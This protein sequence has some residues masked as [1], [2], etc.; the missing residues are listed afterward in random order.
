MLRPS[1]ARLIGFVAGAAL[2]GAPLQAQLRITGAISGT[3]QDPSGGAVAGAELALR[4]EGTGIV[5]KGAASAAGNFTFPDLAHGSYELTVTAPGFQQAVVSRITVSTSQTTDVPVRLAV[6]QQSETV[7]VEG[8]APALERTS[9]LVTSTLTPKQITEL[10]VANRSNVLALAR[11]APGATP[12]TQGSTRYNN[13]PGGAVNV[14]VDGINDA[15]NGFKSGGTVFFMTVPVRVGAVEEVSVET[16]GLGAE[17]GAQSGANIKFVTKRGSNQF[18]GSLFYEPNNY[19]FNANSW[20]RNAQGLDRTVS[21]TYDFGGS[22]GGPMLKEKLFFFVNFER[23]YSPQNI[24]R[25]VQVLTPEAQRG[26]YKYF[27]AGSTTQVAQVNVLE[28]AARNGAPNTLDPVT[29]SMIAFNNQIPANATQ[30]ADNDL[31]RDT[32][33]WDANNNNYAYFPTIRLDY[34]LTQKHQLTA[35]WNYRHNWQPGESRLP[36]PDLTRTNPFRLGYFVW[37]GAVQST[38]SPRMFNELR[39]GVQHS[40]DTNTSSD[41]P[42][43]F[44]YNGQPLRING[45][46]PAGLPIGE[47]PFN[48]PI[49]GIDQ[50]NTTGRHYITTIYDTLTMTKGEHQLTMGGSFRRTD[51]NDQGEVFQIPTYNA[52]TPAGDPLPSLLFNQATMP[53][54]VNTDTG[55]NSGANALYNTLT[56]RVSQAN[57]RRVVDP[58]SFQY[59]GFINHTWTRSN[60]GGLFIQDRWRLKPSLTLNYGLRWE[61]QAPMHDVNGL[62][63][64]P[65]LASLYGPSTALFT[66]GQLSGNNNPTVVVGRQAYKTDWLNFAPN[67]GFAWNP[68][69][70][71]GFLGKLLGG[72]R[73]VFRGSWGIV[74]Y[75]EGTQMFAQNL[76]T[77][78]G[79]QIDSNLIPGQGSLPAFYT[80][81]NVAANPLTPASFSFQTLTYAQ[82]INQADQTFARTISGM[83]PTLRAPYTINWNLGFQR[84]LAKSL[85]VELRYVAN[86]GKLAWRT[87]NLNEVNIFENGFLAEFQRAQRNLAIN[88]ANGV[89]SFQNRGLPGQSDLPIFDAAF[90]ARGGVPAIAPGSGYTSAGFITNLQTGAAGA[91]AGS[92]ASSREY[93]CRM[94]GST[95]SPCSRI[96]AA[97]NAPGPYPINFFLLNPYAIGNGNAAMNFVDD[98]GSSSYNGLQ[99]QLRKAYSRGLQWTFNYTLSKGMTNLARD[100]ANQGLDWGSLRNQ[101]QDREW[102]LSAFDVTHVIQTYGTYELPVGRG[103]AL[104]ISNGVLN[105]LFGG[106]TL[107]SVFVFNTG[108]PFLLTGGYQTVNTSGNPLTRGVRLAPGVTVEQIQDMWNAPLRPVTGRVGATPTQRLAVDPRLIGPDGRANPA[109]LLPNTTPGEFGDNIFIR[110]R[111]T[112]VW[113]A[114]LSKNVRLTSRANLQ[115]FA[116][117]N[118]VLNHPL[119]NLGNA[120]DV[121]PPVVMDVTSTSFGLINGPNTAGGLGYRTINLRATVT[122]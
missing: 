60:M 61:A 79:K 82:T 41:Y 105:G 45:A 65:D 47:L 25:Q 16:G 2:L 28:L 77:N 74:Y 95:F 21:K 62:T 63:A 58:D 73:T 46:N 6:G 116:S 80:F 121:P 98:T 70:D 35:T 3:V 55:A 103:K 106:W 30:I 13:L 32:Y 102:R 107:G 31:N 96:N 117:F 86:R 53:G 87:S 76:G 67:V 5:R 12:P 23:S 24:P 34:F 8:V 56:G 97:Y 50:Q 90:G 92:L 114:S 81:N 49:P 120:A 111:N 37:S 7:T 17:S 88:L 100:V 83:D 72:Q 15:S 119:W 4:D 99:F 91:L 48:V 10:P 93:V 71:T 36:V 38:L 66:P 29:Q 110:D 101:G 9:Q 43:Y 39:F 33:A 115:L 52:G 59:D 69:R 26:I 11:L 118:N 84:E 27:V 18:H 122:F 64:S 108:Q 19:K 113:N 14:T 109:F 75:D 85:V 112:F 89:N 57:F 78:A 42:Q 68:N 22:L 20:T 104:D 44:T 1:V 54:I 40:G 51:W 94:F